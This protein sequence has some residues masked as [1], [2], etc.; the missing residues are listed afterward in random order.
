[1]KKVK[2]LFPYLVQKSSFLLRDF[3]AGIYEDTEGQRYY[4]KNENYIKSGG[5]K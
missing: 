4:G 2:A 5:S 3:N 1:M